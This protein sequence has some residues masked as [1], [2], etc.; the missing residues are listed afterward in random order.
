MGKRK[1]C[2]ATLKPT[3]G[4]RLTTKKSSKIIDRSRQ[5]R[6]ESQYYPGMLM[7]FRMT[8]REM[9]GDR[10]TPRQ[11]FRTAQNRRA[12]RR[13]APPPCDAWPPDGLANCAPAA[14]PRPPAKENAGPPANRR[15]PRASVGFLEKARPP[16]ASVGSLEPTPPASRPQASQ[17]APS[18]PAAPAHTRT[19]RLPPAG[20][21]RWSAS[22]RGDASE[23]ARFR[24]RPRGAR[25]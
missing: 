11:R 7:L 17:R 20:T 21:A 16:R 10:K 8:T 13:S 18:P 1:I 15:P 6:G 23:G 19:Q 5:I 14:R 2:R 3:T 24:G 12:G 22:S 25:R 9:N 4:R